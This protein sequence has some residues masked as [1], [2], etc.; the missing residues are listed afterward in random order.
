MSSEASMLQRISLALCLFAGGIGVA[1][2]SS[3][4]TSTTSTSAATPVTRA[5]KVDCEKFRTA[6]AKV[7]KIAASGGAAPTTAAGELEVITK[8]DGA[9]AK[10]ISL[11]GT[12]APDLVKQWNDLTASSLVKLNDSVKAGDSVETFNKVLQT[13]NDGDYKTVSESL[14][15][16]VRAACPS[17]YATTTTTMPAGR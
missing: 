2:C 1:A 17:I 9:S 13:V 15:S 4:S 11:L 12:V 14:G 10:A 6:A 3:S 8:L 5:G 7:S 16:V